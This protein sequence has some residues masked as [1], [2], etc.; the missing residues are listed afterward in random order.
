MPADDDEDEDG[1]ETWR[2]KMIKAL[3]I[4]GQLKRKGKFDMNSEYMRQRGKPNKAKK[5][6]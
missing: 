4:V 6:K 1:K 2:E 5:I 3:T